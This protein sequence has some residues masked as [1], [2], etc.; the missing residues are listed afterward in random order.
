MA[1]FEPPPTWVVPIEGDPKIM[2]Q[3]NLRFNRN[4]LKWFIDLVAALNT[5]G[6]SSLGTVTSVSVTTS[7]G[8]TASVANPTTTPQLSIGLG[9]ILPATPAGV[10][11]VVC[12]LTAGSGAPSN[13][14]GINGDIYFRSDGGGGTAVYQKRAG[15]WVGIV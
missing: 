2:R 9:K 4:W 8:V 12:H 13:G 6:G 15:A 7:E 11:Q 10:A 1:V 14:D 3:L 5:G